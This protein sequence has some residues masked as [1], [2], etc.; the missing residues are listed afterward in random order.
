MRNSLAVIGVG[1][2]AKAIINGILREESQSNIS[3]ISLFDVNREQYSS[4]LSDVISE[5][6]S[7]DEA[8]ESCD[9]VLISVKPQNYPEVL[10]SIKKANRY[11]DKLYISIGAGISTDFVKA[12]LG[13]VSVIRA[14]PNLPM[15][16]GKGVTAICKNEN[17]AK[18]DMEFV[19]GVFMSSGSIMMI[20]EDEMNRII[21]VTSSSPAYVFK[22][23]AAICEGAKAQGICKDTLLDV[24]CDMVIGSAE[25]LKN[26]DLTPDE[27]ISRVASKGGTTERALIT[28]DSMDFDNA[29][30][31]AMKACTDRAD[32]LGNAK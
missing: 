26:S 10:D 27:L 24:I 16:I 5:T 2:M 21:G 29:I 23:I 17:V 7:I 4:M 14:L 20:S 3:C 13:D 18:E 6:K 30:F 22:F 19:Q 9:T 8:I 12:S 1:N 25:M 15:V 32:E 31:K 28:L 11:K